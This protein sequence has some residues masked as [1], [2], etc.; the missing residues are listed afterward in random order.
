MFRQDFKFD[1]SIAE[2]N[3]CQMQSILMER[4]DGNRNILHACINMCVPISN[5]EM[6]QGIEHDIVQNTVDGNNSAPMEEPIST[7]SWPPEAF[8]NTSGEEDSLLSIGVASIST[9]NKSG[10]NA[11]NTY[12]IDS[13][14]RRNNA[15]LILKYMCESQVLAPHLKELLSAR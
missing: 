10:S 13:V 6:E 7:L 4:C 3:T 2:A 5:K 15:L 8:D 14:E 9:L 1:C 12:I 11:N